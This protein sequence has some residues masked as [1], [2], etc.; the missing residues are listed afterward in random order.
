M[1]KTLLKFF[2]LLT[3]IIIFFTIVIIITR[4]FG[5]QTEQKAPNH[6]FKR[7]SLKMIAHRGGAL[8]APENTLVAFDQAIKVSSHFILE[9]D[10]HLTKDEH[11]A[12]IHDDTVDRTTNG[13]G[14]VANMTLT[15]LQKLDAGWHYQNNEGEYIYRSQGIQVPSLRQSARKIPSTKN[16]Y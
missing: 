11:L 8:E 9:M 4:H 15:E 3:V 2:L 7:G 10:I 6:Q 5:F 14:A 12:V 13:E 1:K 16:D